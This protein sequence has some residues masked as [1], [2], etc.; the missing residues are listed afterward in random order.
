M[1]ISKLECWT[2]IDNTN[3]VIKS[4]NFFLDFVS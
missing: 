4:V 3:G 1:Y 2:D